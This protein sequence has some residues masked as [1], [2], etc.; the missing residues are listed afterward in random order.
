MKRMSLT[1]ALITTSLLLG[2]HL[3]NKILHKKYKNE[4]S[5]SNRGHFLQM[6]RPKR[7]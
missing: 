4:K 2:S 1:K 5:N 3:I 7:S 6:Q